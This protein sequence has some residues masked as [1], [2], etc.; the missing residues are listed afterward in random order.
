MLL[1][2]GPRHLSPSPA[3]LTNFGS[4]IMILKI[5]A[6]LFETLVASYK[7]YKTGGSLV[8]FCMLSALS[9]ATRSA[10]LSCEVGFLLCC[11][12]IVDGW[13]LAIFVAGMSLCDLDLLASRGELASIF[14]KAELFK[15]PT[16]L[17]LILVSLYL[18]AV[19]SASS[20]YEVLKTSPGW[21]Y[22][23]WLGPESMA[24]PKWSYLFWAA[25]LFVAATP[26]LPWLQKFFNSTFNQYLGRI[27]FSLYLMHGP[28]IRTLGNKIYLLLG[29]P[30]DSAYF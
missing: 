3:R 29:W 13:F 16:F 7:L 10:R 27:S 30:K 6:L 1:A 22:L 11:L 26:R 12:C 20:D 2:F 18:G 5:I 23:S 28:L 8:V 25:V 17:S 24:Q 14:M 19:P 4:G 9:S 15:V 21:L